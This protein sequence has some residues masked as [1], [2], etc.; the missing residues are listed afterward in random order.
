MI[1][2]DL[3]VTASKPAAITDNSPVIEASNLI[4]A[5]N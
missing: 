1:D 5:D 3:S 2:V 4:L